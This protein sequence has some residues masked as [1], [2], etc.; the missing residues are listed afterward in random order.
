M[1]TPQE[2]TAVTYIAVGATLTMLVS[3]LLCACG[4][5]LGFLIGI[6]KGLVENAGG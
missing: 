6:A 4:G 2:K 1:M 5:G 3:M